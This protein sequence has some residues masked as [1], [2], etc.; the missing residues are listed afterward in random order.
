MPRLLGLG[1]AVG[2][3]LWAVP[4][5]ADLL[6]HYTFDDDT[7]TT[8]A[9]DSGVPPAADGTFVLNATRTNQTPDGTGFALNLDVAGNSY[10][11]VGNPAKLNNLTNL[12]ITFWINLRRWFAA[13]TDRVIDKTLSTSPGTGGFGLRS[14]SST[15]NLTFGIDYATA[16]GPVS[17][18]FPA[19]NEWYFVAV[20]YDGTRSNLNIR[21]FM[22][23][24]TT[25]AVGTAPATHAGWPGG[26]LPNSSA[27][28]RIGGTDAS[29][30][31]RSP[32]A[33][34][35]DVR[36]YNVVLSP[37]EIESIRREVSNLPQ[38][39]A[40]LSFTANGAGGVPLPQATYVTGGADILL[41]AAVAGAA[42][43]SVQMFRNGEALPGAA[44]T[45]AVNAAELT[46]ALP[47]GVPEHAGSYHVVVTNSLGAATSSIPALEIT[48]I[49]DSAVMAE[50]WTVPPGIRDYLA[51]SGS[52]T[53]SMAFNRA[54][55]A[56]SDRG[57]LVLARWGNATTKFV[58][59]L[60]P[61]TG[62]TG[63]TLATTDGSSIDM[64]IGNRGIN[65]VGAADDGALYVGNLVISATNLPFYLYRYASD[66][67]TSVLPAVAYSGDPGGP[68]YPGLRWGD[69]LAVRGAGASTEI[70]L[71][72]AGG[73]NFGP[74]GTGNRVWETNIVALLRT[75]DGLTFTST[76]ILV[77]NAPADFATLGLAFGPGSNTFF[78]KNALNRLFFVQFDVT[79]GL[80]WVK[81]ASSLTAVPACVVA[82][83]TDP[84]RQYLAALS[85]ETPDNLRLYSIADPT[86]DP[87]L[88]DQAAFEA[89]NDNSLNG[90]AGSVVWGTNALYVLDCN[91]G[92][93]AF[94][95]NTNY[96][97][98]SAFSISGIQ[99]AAWPGVAAIVWP[100][101]AG[102][103]YQVQSRENLADTGWA[104]VGMP[105]TGGGST[106][107]VTNQQLTGS[108]T[109][110]F[111]RV[112][113][114]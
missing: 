31:R 80:G 8:F 7:N 81:H 104:R 78:A 17:P 67:Y 11:R 97:P 100:A 60:D 55:V 75:T 6:L 79:A 34:V 54:S 76:P 84:A 47:G 85:I 28:L 21:W 110:R 48:T 32:Y 53:R 46:A 109:N 20:T 103:T 90:G 13:S 25:P 99:P 102:R 98:P 62:D 41:S 92:V 52:Q 9:A 1:W 58:Q 65:V 112:V 82:L 49:F 111:F 23:S 42:P 18:D 10:V 93:K 71:G 40:V 105:V 26:P 113:A 19:T 14:T 63:P 87:D 22:G 4:A 94:Q 72:P 37:V 43:L 69:S 16:A 5:R 56:Y 15:R 95:I 44:A 66:D 12:T 36:L 33:W 3:L 74:L 24:R 83:G 101:A 39:P 108:V 106:V 61:A 57:S 77:T 68:D 50:L 86:R 2:V 73:P 88:M 27:N 51:S 30:A 29:T 38:E 91:N 45:F 64:T 89:N 96:A 35:D 114:Q 107:T 70:L 59:L